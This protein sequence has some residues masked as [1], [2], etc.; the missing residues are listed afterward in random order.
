M[1]E[2][3]NRKK[4][5]NEIRESMNFDTE[6][7][8]SKRKLKKS[9]VVEGFFKRFFHFKINLKEKNQNKRKEHRFEEERL[10]VWDEITKKESK[11]FHDMD[12]QA[13]YNLSKIIPS[14]ISKKR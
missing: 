14:E 11:E 4:N 7:F 6:V 10:M 8:K 13:K 9:K 5:I 3:S 1:R 12:L 2:I